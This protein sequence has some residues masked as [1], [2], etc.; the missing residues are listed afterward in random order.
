M[1][2]MAVTFT[3]L[4]EIASAIGELGFRRDVGELAF[5]ELVPAREV[6]ARLMFACLPRCGSWMELWP[7]TRTIFDEVLRRE[8]PIN[9]RN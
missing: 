5:P 4:D 8:Q 3:T 9:G 6:L 2:H 7:N 1:N